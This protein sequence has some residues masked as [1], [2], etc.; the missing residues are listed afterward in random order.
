MPLSAPQSILLLATSTGVG[1]VHMLVW[2]LL[3]AAVA[4]KRVP[5]LLSFAVLA[6]VQFAGTLF[7]QLTAVAAGENHALISLAILTALLIAA[8]VVISARGLLSSARMSAAASL[9]PVLVLA[10]QYELSPR[11][12]EIAAIWLSGHSSAY[13]ERT[14]NISKNTVKTHLSHIYQK[15]GAR[16]REGLLALIESIASS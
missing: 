3:I 13:I 1:L 2:L 9:D 11:E 16:N 7:G 12:C 5:A 6:T 4:N 14:L 15:T 10:S 8:L